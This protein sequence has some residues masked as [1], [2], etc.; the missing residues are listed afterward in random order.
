MDMP[1]NPRLIKKNFPLIW[2]MYLRKAIEW[3]VW[4]IVVTTKW[5]SSSSLSPCCAISMDIPDPLS[6]PLPIVHC[7]WQ[8]FWAISPIGIEL[9]YVGLSWLSC[10]CS[11]MWRGPQEYIIYELVPTS[12]A[13]YCLSGSSN[14]NSFRDG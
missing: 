8:V 7:F 11:S 5:N 10:L 1:Q 4:N 2:I 6:P 12:L 13:V 9:L 3:I 14:L